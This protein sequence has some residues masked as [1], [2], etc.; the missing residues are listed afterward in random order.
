MT[1]R[2]SGGFSALG[3]EVF[4]SALAVETAAAAAA[5]EARN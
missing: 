2:I 3:F 4:L 5:V 1:Y